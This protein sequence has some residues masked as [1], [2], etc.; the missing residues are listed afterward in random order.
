M[1]DCFIRIIYKGFKIHSFNDD[2][3]LVVQHS[4]A[5]EIHLKHS[6][7]AYKTFHT[8]NTQ[9]NFYCY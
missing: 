7:V 3:R 8:F 9:T 5:T 4:L 6:N 2:I 1:S